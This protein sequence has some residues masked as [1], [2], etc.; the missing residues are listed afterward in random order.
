M[1]ATDPAILIPLF[2]RLKLRPKVSQT[3]VA[4]SACNDV[5]GTVLTLTLVGAVEAGGLTFSGP[6][7]EFTKELALGALIG[8]VAGA[9]LCYA[10]ASTTR[11]GI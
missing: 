4:E 9:I 10:I 7:L 11:A 2:E 3:V 5:T 8:V 6:A 1:A